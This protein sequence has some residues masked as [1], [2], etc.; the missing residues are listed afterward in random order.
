MA[1][2][3]SKS[4]SDTA[5]STKFPIIAHLHACSKCSDITNTLIGISRETAPDG[6][7]RPIYFVHSG[8]I[9]PAVVLNRSWCVTP[10]SSPTRGYWPRWP[11]QPILNILNIFTINI[12]IYIYIYIHLTGNRCIISKFC[13]FARIYPASLPPWGDHVTSCGSGSL[14]DCHGVS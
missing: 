3:S 7:N 10:H 11:L 8:A 13:Y 4:R 12:Y 2:K 5:V 14:I 9:C 6:W 1:T